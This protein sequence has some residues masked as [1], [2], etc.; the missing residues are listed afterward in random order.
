MPPEA[1]ERSLE[2]KTFTLARLLRLTIPV[3]AVITAMLL[4]TEF[5][6]GSER[7]Y[8]GKSLTYWCDQ[9]PPTI[10]IPGVGFMVNRSGESQAEKAISTLGTNCL[11]V[12]LSRLQTEYSPIRFALRKALAKLRVIRPQEVGQWQVRR[13][14]ALTGIMLL[15]RNADRVLP[16]LAILRGSADPWLSSAAAYMATEIT[17]AKHEDE[18]LEIGR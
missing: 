17:A 16:K 1:P 15:G 7:R 18:N 10:Q 12:L 6:N 9:L 13:E 14:Q 2:P 3:G 4:V 8:A 5:R 11:P